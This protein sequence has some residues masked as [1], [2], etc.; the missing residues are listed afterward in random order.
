MADMNEERKAGYNRPTGWIS[1]DN[2]SYNIQ[3]IFDDGKTFISNVYLRVALYRKLFLK[4]F[5]AKSLVGLRLRVYSLFWPDSTVLFII[6][7]SKDASQRV[8]RTA[9]CTCHYSADL[10]EMT[11]IIAQDAEIKVKT[12][13]SLKLRFTIEHTKCRHFSIFAALT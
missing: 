1:N 4:R 13:A 12:I 3:H 2:W 9:R 11:R 7:I 6:S 5:P 10:G 8:F